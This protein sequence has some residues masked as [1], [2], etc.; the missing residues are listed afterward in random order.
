MPIG[1]RGSNPGRP[2]ELVQ[3]RVAM[4]RCTNWPPKLSTNMVI[5]YCTLNIQPCMIHL[6]VRSNT[7]IKMKY[8]SCLFDKCIMIYN[9]ICIPILV[10]WIA[11][12]PDFDPVENDQNLS[13]IAHTTKYHSKVTMVTLQSTKKCWPSTALQ[14]DIKL[15]VCLWSCQNMWNVLCKIDFLTWHQFSLPNLQM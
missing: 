7:L 10:C 15:E 13:K 1:V 2:G 5:D 9:H 8:H 3:N 4:S 12:L 6:C 14:K 11:V